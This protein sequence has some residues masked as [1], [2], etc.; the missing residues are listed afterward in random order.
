MFKLCVVRQ[1]RLRCNTPNLSH[2]ALVN[3]PPVQT[4]KDLTAF[5]ELPYHLYKNDPV[6]VP[7]LRR[8]RVYEMGI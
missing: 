3:I 2:E 4:K 1:V 8:Y 5:I 7:P 6:W